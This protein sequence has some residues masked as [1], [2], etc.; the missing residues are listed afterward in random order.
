MDGGNVATWHNRTYESHTLVA[1]KLFNGQLVFNSPNML[2]VTITI[3]LLQKSNKVD[4]MCK[5]DV[6]KLLYMKHIQSYDA[7]TEQLTYFL[8]W[9]L[10]Y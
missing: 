4:Y 5:H 8:M 6:Y 7:T 9:E 3:Q 10:I 1:K 2:H